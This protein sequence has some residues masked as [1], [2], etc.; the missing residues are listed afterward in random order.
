VAR[1]FFSQ[2]PE[3]KLHDPASDFRSE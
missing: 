3:P 1:G 2:T